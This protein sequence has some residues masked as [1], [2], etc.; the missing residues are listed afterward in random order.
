MLLKT[1]SEIMPVSYELGT[2]I[3]IE[4][5]RQ[6]KTCYSKFLL[7]VCLGV[8]VCLFFGGTFC[9]LDCLG[10]VLENCYKLISAGERLPPSSNREN[11]FTLCK[12]IAAGF[13]LFCSWNTL[14]TPYSHR[15]NLRFKNIRDLCSWCNT[16]AFKSCSSTILKSIQRWL[17]KCSEIFFLNLIL[18][19]KLSFKVTC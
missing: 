15:T 17:Y 16:W 4:A 2:N 5:Y 13:P 11:P 6:S 9:L 7:W 8:F 1:F 10:F 18:Y 14:F 3:H 12:E 19:D